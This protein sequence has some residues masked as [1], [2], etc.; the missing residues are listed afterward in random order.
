VAPPGL[1]IGYT[2]NFGNFSLNNLNSSIVFFT[3]DTTNPGLSI[4]NPTN[5]SNLS[6]DTFDL[7]Y[8]FVETN[9]G[10]C[11]YSNDSGIA[12]SSYVSMG[13]NWT[14]LKGTEG[15]INRTIY[16]NDTL[17]NL[18]SSIIFFTIDTINPNVNITYP[19]NNT[20]YTDTGIPI[21]YTRDDS[22][23]GIDSCWYHNDTNTVNTT[24]NNCINI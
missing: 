9:P 12:N 8:T 3:I 11:W 19:I 16:C 6:S 18:N 13:T 23:S 5:L 22:G 24:L 10:F 14:D 17:D 1:E 7:N 20:D 15:D 4:A 2:G 21:N